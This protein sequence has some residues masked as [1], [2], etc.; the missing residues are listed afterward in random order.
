[1]DNVF[2]CNLYVSGDKSDVLHFINENETEDT[3]LSFSESVPLDY[4]HFKYA[5]EQWGCRYDCI[6][7]DLKYISNDD[8][9]MNVVYIFET[10]GDVP[11][12]YLES[13]KNMK[14]WKR[15]TFTMSFK[16]IEYKEPQESQPDQ[17]NSDL[18]ISDLDQYDA[19]LSELGSDLSI[20]DLETGSDLSEL[21]SDISELKSD[22]SELK[23]DLSISDLE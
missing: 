10:I 2:T 4:D 17:F 15:L 8:I 5:L 16:S 23:S 11:H 21:K 18:S 6:E 3:V 19:N 1:M 14:E 12:I 13:L 9:N 22:L 7:P 20:S